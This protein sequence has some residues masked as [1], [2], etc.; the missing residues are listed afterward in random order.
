M[1]TT[2]NPNSMVSM[3]PPFQF[4]ALS[5]GAAMRSAFQSPFGLCAAAHRA[6]AAFRADSLRSSA[7]IFRTRAFPPRRPSATAAGFFRLGAIA[8]TI[9]EAVRS[10]K[11]ACRLA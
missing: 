6:R 1:N 9:C 2:D 11:P 4:L 10:V 5:G 8:S 3:L 7:V